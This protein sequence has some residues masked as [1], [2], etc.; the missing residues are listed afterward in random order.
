[1][2]DPLR[3]YRQMSMI[4]HILVLP[5]AILL[6]TST[7]VAQ[8]ETDSTTVAAAD[9][10]AADTFRLMPD[11]PIA[12]MLDSL[13]T[14][15]YYCGFEAAMDSAFINRYSLA[16]DS[17]PP[18]DEAYIA[19][20]LAWLDAESPFNLE[21]NN[22]VRGFVHLYSVRRRGLTA[23][24]LGLSHLYFPMIEAEL[25]RQ[26][27][28]MEFKYL[29]V[30]E[31]AL[32]PNAKSR[33]GAVGLWQ[34][35]YTTGKLFDLQVNSYVDE[36]MDPYQSTVAA[37]QYFKRLYKMY[38][39]WEL[40]LA[41]YNCGPGNVNRAI[42]KSGGKTD[43][44]ELWPYLPRETRG[45]VPAFIAVNYIM[46]N[47]QKHNIYPVSPITTAFEIDTVYTR[48]QVTFEQLTGALE[49]SKPFLEYLN[50]Q[51]KQGIVPHTREPR[52]IILPCDK[53]GLFLTNEEAVYAYGLEPAVADSVAE[54]EEMIVQETRTTHIVRRGEYLGIIAQRYNVKVADI[55]GW[56][57]LRSS[58]LQ[59]GQKLTIY[60]TTETLASKPSTPTN[61]AAGPHYYTIQKGDTLWDIARAR[62]LSVNQ[63]RSMNSNLNAGSLK[64]GTKI[65]VGNPG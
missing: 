32:R 60:Q 4:R 21:Y 27:L 42:R 43:Y 7:L 61:T 47:A 1:M 55:K 65:V 38:G 48:K 28:P 54:A 51:Y 36:R 64:P 34:F 49:V 22:K 9:S 26:N 35:M 33:A 41:A 40:V 17:V 23:R 57:G 16:Q 6:A 39:N 15:M 2:G 13:Y 53:V 12:Q 19:E 62:G 11:H 24:M 30:V 56:N 20:Q 45:Y 8:T 44:W 5:I 50:P 52:M 59:P 58:R 3:I 25:D 37:C 14:S 63:L 18:I 10:V 29:A 31:S 46:N